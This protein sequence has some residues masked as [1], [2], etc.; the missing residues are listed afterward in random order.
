MNNKVFIP[1]VVVAVVVGAFV[2]INAGGGDEQ[3]NIT[4]DTSSNTASA[5]PIQPNRGEA[6]NAESTGIDRYVVYSDQVLSEKTDTKKVLFFHA[7]WCSVCNAFEKEIKAQGV[8]EGITIVKASFDKDTELKKE[9]GVTIQSTFVLL[10]ESNEV[11]RVWP[12]GQGLGGISD[13]YKEV[14]ES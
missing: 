1:I 12:F 5:K 3:S 9:Y 13:L 7:D 14:S 2:F 4:G 6:T 8:P 10:D 11:V